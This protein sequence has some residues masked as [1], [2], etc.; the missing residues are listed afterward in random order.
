MSWS[1]S[2]SVPSQPPE[3]LDADLV[4]LRGLRTTIEQLVAGEPPSGRGPGGVTT[5]FTLS[6]SDEVRLDPSGSGW[7][8]L[9][10]ALWARSC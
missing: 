5:S 4:K 3:L 8:W 2:T 10:S 6:E 1:A 9:A 7:R